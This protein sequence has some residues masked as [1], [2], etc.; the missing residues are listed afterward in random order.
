MSMKSSPKNGFTYFGLDLVVFES[1]LRIVLSIGVKMMSVFMM[2][3]SVL[4]SKNGNKHQIIVFRGKGMTASIHM[5]LCYTRKMSL[6]TLIKD[7]HQKLLAS[8]CLWSLFQTPCNVISPSKMC[9]FK[10][11][12]EWIRNYVVKS[13][14][15]LRQYN[16]IRSIKQATIKILYV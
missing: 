15:F 4:F 6:K 10:R 13:V 2:S 3:V 12:I 9:K 1:F 14:W 7:L 11:I 8:S 5:I 16:M